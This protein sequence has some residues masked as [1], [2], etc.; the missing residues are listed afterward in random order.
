LILLIKGEHDRND[1][2]TLT[3]RSEIRKPLTQRRKS[4]QNAE[5]YKQQVFKVLDA[6]KTQVRFNSEWLEK[7]DISGTDQAPGQA[8][9]CKDAGTGGL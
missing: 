5:T 8:D 6:E 7:D 4:L 1:R 9:C 3:G 2:W